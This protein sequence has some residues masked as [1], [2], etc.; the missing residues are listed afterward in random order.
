MNN[1]NDSVLIKQCQTVKFSYKIA[2]RVRGSGTKS[3]F[4][5]EITSLVAII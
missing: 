2:Y 3:I 4:A 1:R 5:T